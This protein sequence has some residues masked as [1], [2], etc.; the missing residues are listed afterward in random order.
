MDNQFVFY[1][2]SADLPPGKGKGTKWS[3]FVNNPSDYNE[4]ASIPDWR[5]MF[6]NMY[7]CPFRLGGLTWNSVEHFFH[8]MKYKGKYD[9]YYR[10]FSLES[11]SKWSRNPFEAKSAGKAGRVNAS[12]K[13]YTNSKLGVPTN[14]QMRSDFYT[15]GINWQ[16]MKLALIAKFTQCPELTRALLAT[17]DAK[18]YHLITERGKPSQ[19]QRW[20]HLEDIRECIKRFNNP[21]LKNV[22]DDTD[23]AYIDKF[24]STI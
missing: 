6:S 11:D 23:D 15:R 3:E 1:S 5:K 16:V 14:V 21:D 20:T 8:A 17:K 22:L 7:E 12:G 10:S 18:L 2:K 4:L 9:N 24:L 13:V 19:L